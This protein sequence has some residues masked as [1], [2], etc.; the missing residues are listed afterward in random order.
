M[1]DPNSGQIVP[2]QGQNAGALSLPQDPAALQGQLAD[3]QRAQLAQQP[4]SLARRQMQAQQAFQG[5]DPRVAQA[6][7]QQQ[8]LKSILSDVQSSAPENEDP[9]DLQARLSARIL[10]T[11][12]QT[13]PQL[14]MQ[15]SQRLVQIQEAKAQRGLLSARA[16]AE[17]LGVKKAKFEL[18]AT[19]ATP[20][21][22]YYV[23]PSNPDSPPLASVSLTGNDGKIRDPA[24]IAGDMK[25]IQAKNPNG[26]LVSGEQLWNNK[27]QVANIR[28][29]ALITAAMLRAQAAAGK[30]QLPAKERSDFAQASGGM[31]AMGSAVDQ[32]SDFVDKFPDANTWAQAGSKFLA[33]MGAQSQAAVASRATTEDMGASN[34]AISKIDVPTAWGT[35]RGV[36]QSM[37][38]N[39][40]WTLANSSFKGR[41]TNQEIMQAKNIIGDSP[42]PAQIQQNLSNLMNEKVSGRGGYEGYLESRGIQADEAIAAAHQGNVGYL[43][44]VMGRLQARVNRSSGK[45]GGGASAGP[46]KSFVSEAEATAARQRGEISNGDKIKI[47]GRSATWQD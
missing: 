3:I 7:A 36:Y 20:R 2:D 33:N 26:M 5:T 41:V 17:Q 16:E 31:M 10:T 37:V 25:D 9:L 44:E 45:G 12:G 21:M 46:P 38:A 35:E 32:L 27:A 24:D 15:A 42:N 11:M 30:S 18:E 19:A 43:H 23:D 28:A 6:Q 47:G 4:S 1:I 40:A 14:A 29:N 22:M 13:N 34:E 8:Q 39:L